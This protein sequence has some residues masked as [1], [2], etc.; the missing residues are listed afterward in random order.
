MTENGIWTIITSNWTEVQQDE[1]IGLYNYKMFNVYK[2]CIKLFTKRFMEI[3]RVYSCFVLLEWYFYSDMT[4]N[5]QKYSCYP[6]VIIT[7]ITWLNTIIKVFFFAPTI[8]PS[9]DSATIILKTNSIISCVPNNWNCCLMFVLLC[10]KP[11][12]YIIFK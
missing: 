9:K 1:S 11:S 6:Q 12:M 5:S 2:K 10:S 4:A 7:C 3:I 8:F